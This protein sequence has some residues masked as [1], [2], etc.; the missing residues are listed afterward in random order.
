VRLPHAART[1]V[2]DQVE[3]ALRKLLSE[4]VVKLT[5]EGK[6]GHKCWPAVLL[7]IAARPSRTPDAPQHAVAHLIAQVL[8]LRRAVP[9]EHRMEVVRFCRRIVEQTHGLGVGRLRHQR[10]MVKPNGT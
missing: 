10:K 9:E 7:E 1:V 5:K 4:E 6:G 8:D 2:S 3:A